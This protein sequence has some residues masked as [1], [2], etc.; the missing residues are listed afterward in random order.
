MVRSPVTRPPVMVT[1]RLA[2][3]S[4]RLDSWEA[5]TTVAPPADASVTSW[6]RRVRAPASRPA[7]GSSSNQSSGDRATNTARAT[8]RRCPAESFPALV[9]NSRP[10]RPSRSQ[11]AGIRSIEPPAARTANLTFSRTD[12][13][14]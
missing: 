5:M 14:S 6:P 2:N 10:A 9:R 12:R 7:W 8:R 4:T 13:S 3:G 1:A 11:A